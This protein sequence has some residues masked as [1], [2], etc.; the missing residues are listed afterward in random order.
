MKADVLR[1]C[2]FCAHRGDGKPYA[3]EDY[4]EHHQRFL[5]AHVYPAV[6]AFDRTHPDK[7]CPDDRSCGCITQ[8]E[9]ERRLGVAD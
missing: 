7:R 6:K 9:F 8:E 1:A 2:P 3:W 4:C 5:E